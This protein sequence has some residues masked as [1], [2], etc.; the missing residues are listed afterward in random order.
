VTDKKLP[1]KALWGGYDENKVTLYICRARYKG[2]LHP[3]KLISSVMVCNIGWGGKEYSFSDYDVL[4]VTGPIAMLWATDPHDFS[5]AVPGGFENGH[6]LYICHVFFDTGLP[7]FE[8]HH[9]LQ[10]G[11]VTD[12][13]ERCQFPFGGVEKTD[14]TFDL[15]EAGVSAGSGQCPAGTSTCSCPPQ[16]SLCCPGSNVGCDC[17][18][19]FP[20]CQ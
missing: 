5:K 2:G 7:T 18:F 15:L 4:T 16:L 20:R 17:T 14:T 13:H 6:T 3:G 12:D 8:T 11:K 9:G 19:G 10:L 1:A